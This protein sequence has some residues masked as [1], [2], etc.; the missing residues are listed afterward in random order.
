MI[1]PPKVSV[2]LEYA[3]AKLGCE[4]A[5]MNMAKVAGL[6]VTIVRPFNVA[7][8]RQ[9]TL[10]GFVLPRFIGQALAGEPIT[11][12]GDGKMV[13]A[14]TDVRDIVDG[15][16][17]VMRLGQNGEAYNIGNPANKTTILDLA[18]KVLQ[19]V[20]GESPITFVDPKNL[21]GPLFEEANDKYPDSERA[22]RELG[23]SPRYDLECTIREAA[24][25]IRERRRD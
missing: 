20:G 19:I 24:D 15:I 1:I 2:R 3:V 16:M 9:S 7:G 22:M 17:R 10:G 11:V 12:Y 4:V 5:L 25:Y 21:W 18:E 14:F 13:R 23:W 6:E 8:S